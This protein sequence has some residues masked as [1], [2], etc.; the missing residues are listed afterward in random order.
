VARAVVALCVTACVTSGVSAQAAG[1]AKTIAHAPKVKFDSAVRGRLHTGAFYS[2]YSV[3]YWNAPLLKGDRVTIKTQASLGDTPPCQVLFMPGTDDI[4]VGATTPILESAS[5]T[6]HASRDVQR[7]V[8]TT[9]GTYVLA[10]TNNDILLSGPQECLSAP[11]GR[12]F[13][14]KVT[15]ARGSGKRSERKG[16][17]GARVALTRVVE[18]GQSLWSIARSLV[19]RKARTANVFFEVQRLWQLNAARIGSGNPDLIFAGLEIRLK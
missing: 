15:V 12:P 3:A 1:G 10:M 13:T 6:R 2:G 7:W 11:A 19:G 8:A 5:A 9:T 16:G 17:K 18:P 4:N 14:F